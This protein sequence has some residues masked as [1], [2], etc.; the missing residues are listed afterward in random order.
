MPMAGHASP[1]P[2]AGGGDRAGRQLI[3]FPPSVTSARGGGRVTP[4][5]MLRGGP[6]QLPIE[7][8]V[9]GLVGATG[10]SHEPAGWFSRGSCWRRLF[11]VAFSFSMPYPY[12]RSRARVVCGRTDGRRQSD[13]G[14]GSA[15]E[16]G[17]CLLISLRVILL[18]SA[19]YQPSPSRH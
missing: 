6:A 19:A 13:R 15:G 9:G 18:Q 8:P 17:R 12:S 4:G 3:G 10:G 16:N 2:P 14:G 1:T 7:G 11:I 5:R